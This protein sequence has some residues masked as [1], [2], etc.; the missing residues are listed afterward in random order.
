MKR[1]IS[2]L[3]FV[4]NTFCLGPCDA[5]DI[6]FSDFATVRLKLIFKRSKHKHLPL[7]GLTIKRLS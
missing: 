5:F 4:L 7:K 6:I 2:P 3:N 1:L